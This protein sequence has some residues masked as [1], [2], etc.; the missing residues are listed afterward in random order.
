[1]E[2]KCA[3]GCP[4][5]IY[6]SWMKRDLTF[7]VKS[8]NDEHIC[9]RNMTNRQATTRWMSKY[10]VEKFRRN[11]NWSVKEMEK[12]LLTKFYLSI[13]RMK[14][15]RSKWEALRKLQGSIEEHYAMLGLYLEQLRIVNPTS[16][17]SIV[18]KRAFTGAHSV[19]QHLYIG[20]DGLK[21]GFMH[22]CR[23]IIGFDGCF[24]KTF[25]G[26]QLLSTVGRDHNNQM[27]P[28]AWAVVEGENYHAWSWFLG[29]L[30]DDLAIDP[31][32]DLTLIS[33]QQ[34][35]L[36]YATKQ[37]VPGAEHRNCACHIYAN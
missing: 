27:F 20:F 29:I 22:G 26:G 16:M 9:S 2:T 7:I 14:A 32:Y 34:K 23:P 35:G 1:M 37:R 25:L 11:T 17:F 21:K 4:W 18:Y 13:S 33:D 31:G 3:M 15:Y 19:F 12:D 8:Y 30:F 5:R 6:G 36:D 10:Y 24:L 28:I